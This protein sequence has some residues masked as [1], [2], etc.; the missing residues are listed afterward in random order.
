MYDN[1]SSNDSTNGDLIIV[2]IGAS[3]GGLEALENMFDSMP[4]DCGLAF[5]I[6]QHLSPDFK[7]LMVE[8]LGRHTSMAIYRVEEGMKVEA[9][10]LYLIPPKQDMIIHDGR[11]RLKERKSTKSLSLP[12]DRFFESLAKDV[13][14]S[15]VAIIL[16]GTGSDGSKGIQSIHSH[17]GLVIV[18]SPETAKFDGMP[19]SA[20]DS[21]FVDIVSTTDEVPSLLREYA[22]HRDKTRLQNSLEPENQSAIQRIFTAIQKRHGVDFSAYRPTTMGRRIERR[23]DLERSVSDLASYSE[24]V[25]RDTDALDRLFQYFLINVTEFFRDP[26]SFEILRDQVLIPL[27]E[28]HSPDEEFRV[29]IAACATGEEAFSVAILIDETLKSLNKHVPVKIFATDI[30]QKSISVATLGVYSEEKL[31]GLS[32]KRFK[33]YFEKVNQGYQIAPAIRRMV[34]FAPQNLIKDPPFKRLSLVLCR[35]FLIY[36]LPQWQGLVLSYLHFGLKT[37]GCLMLGSSET[38]GLLAQEF[39][40][41]DGNSRIYRKLRDTHLAPKFAVDVMRPPSLSL[42]AQRLLTRQV[43]IADR[44]SARSALS[45]S[46][47]FSNFMPPGFVIDRSMVLLQVFRDAGKFL[48]VT[49][50]LLSS[51]ITD[52]VEVDLQVAISGAIQRC[53]K[54]RESVAYDSLQLSHVGSEKKLFKLTVT[55]LP[56]GLEPE[57]F[58]VSF[59]EKSEKA[60]TGKLACPAESIEISDISKDQLAQLE[61]ELR[62]SREVLQATIEEMETSNEEL[63]STNEELIASN[64]ELQSANE[65][66]HSVNEELFTVNAEHQ[67]K[68]KELT[69]LTQDFENLHQSADVHTLFLDKELH[70]R[71]F[72]PRIA[73]VFDLVPHDIGRRIDTFLPAIR[74]ENLS[75]ILSSVL[76]TGKSWEQ[77]VTDSEQTEFL[78]RVLPYRSKEDKPGLVLALIDISNLVAAEAEVAVER[79]RFQ[80]AIQANRDGTWDWPDISKPDMWWSPRCY[81]LLGYEPDAFPATQTEWLTLI[82]PDDRSKIESTTLPSQDKC[83]VELHDDFEYRMRHRNGQYRWYRHCAVI[84]YNDQGKVVRMTGSVADIQERKESQLMATEGIRLR[85]SFLSMLSHELRNPMGA[86]MNALDNIN[87]DAETENE[88]YHPHELTVIQRQTRHMAR[89]LDDLLDVA[90]FGRDRMEFRK[91][92]VNLCSLVDEVIE[93]VDY[94]LNLKQQTLVTSI[95]EGPVPVIGDPA[96][97]IQAQ[98]NLIVNASKFSDSGKQ[99]TYSLNVKNNEVVISIEDEGVGIESDTVDRIFDLFVRL[100]DTLEQSGDGMGVGLSLAQKIVHAH[101]GTIDVKSEGKDKGCTFQIKLPIS[102]LNAEEHNSKTPTQT[103]TQSSDA[104]DLTCKIMLVED[105]VD[106]R[107]MLAKALTRRGFEVSAF[108]DGKS[109]VKAFPEFSPQVAII[110]IGLPKISGHEVAKSIRQNPLW[111]QTLLVALTGYGQ[112]EDGDAIAAAGFDHHLVKP[113]RFEKLHQLLLKHL[114]CAEHVSGSLPPEAVGETPT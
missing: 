27:L 42:N 70:I 106:A 61:F 107:E 88:S 100:E 5:V 3:A 69:E 33:Q 7:S 10:S 17:G 21:D 25:E 50:G 45:Y 109:A 108:A 8:L 63:Q 29:W 53:I 58:V 15:S 113:L 62:N 89:L 48:R 79:E 82:H 77:R 16:S 75:N 84:D 32:E 35:N 20:I 44:V 78:M 91:E 1:G 74:C 92:R 49:D 66:L 103:Q 80:R 52:L 39:E 38:P 64:E 86:V 36:L 112:D 46:E 85:D 43:E 11:L 55:P 54:S 19:Q 104:S 98:T 111:N 60:D 26:E 28:K 67:H 51:R 76:K 41:I 57:K 40:T 72:T 31:K 59:E 97:L 65:E 18:Q 6:V 110:D 4:G 68:I 14:P 87:I 22:Q 24:L 23:I 101:R 102:H 71:R 9:N 99:I 30:D 13:G 12:I 96:R 47:I 93:A 56:P 83:Y 114:S 2:G 95:C 81:E 34:V 73:A 105:N 37:G 90:R 94:Q